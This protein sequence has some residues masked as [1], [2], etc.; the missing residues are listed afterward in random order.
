MRKRLFHPKR[1][2]G[3]V[4]VGAFV[5]VLAGALAAIAAG[6]IMHRPSDT[7]LVIATTQDCRRAFSEEKCN[8]IMAQAMAIHA[9]SAPRYT[10]A[11]LCELNFG[12]GGCAPISLLNT[13]F[14]APAVAAIASTRDTAQATLVPLY[15][16]PKASVDDDSQGL[17]V[18][19]RGLA[20]GVLHRRRFA[21]AELSSLT[22][23]GGKPMTSAEVRKLTRG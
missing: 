7:A 12:V 14:F 20:V 16:E 2:G 8:A 21:G 13:T 15:L 18:F 11:G 22:D 19:Y 23:L 10:D 4:A 3:S 9:S 6:V 1:G 17:R 5:A